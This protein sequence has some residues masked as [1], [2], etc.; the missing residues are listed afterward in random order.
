MRAMA[1]NTTAGNRRRAWRRFF[2]RHDSR[3]GGV[4]W[5][6][7]LQIEVPRGRSESRRVGRA[8]H[9]RET[10]IIMHVGMIFV[11]ESAL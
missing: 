4:L 9:V 1:K 6:K 3:L 7:R 11:V 10:C 5:V 2:T 8:L